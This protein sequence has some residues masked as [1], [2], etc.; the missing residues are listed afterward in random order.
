MVGVWR[1]D[2]LLA[3]ALVLAGVGRAR[4]A[5]RNRAAGLLARRH[6]AFCGHKP[7]VNWKRLLSR[8]AAKTNQ[9]RYVTLLL[10]NFNDKNNIAVLWLRL[11]SE[12]RIENDF[13]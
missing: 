10:S 3:R 9:K 11:F 6:A 2:A 8:S 12:E 1:R 5:R 13:V 4:R 7:W